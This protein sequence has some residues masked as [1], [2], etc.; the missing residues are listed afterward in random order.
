MKKRK[1]L[2]ALLASAIALVPAFSGCSLV[3]SN[4][5]ADMQQVIATVNISEVDGLSTADQNLVDTY[6]DA[7]GTTS[8][9]KRELIAYYLNVGYSYVETYGYE[10][11]F[12]MLVDGLAENAVLTQY[13]TMY[14]LDN[15]ASE[16]P[17]ALSEYNAK[18]TQVGKLEYLLGGENSDDVKIAKY[19]LYSSLN[20][21]IDSYEQIIL[22]EEHNHNTSSDTRTTP[23]NVNTEVEDYYPADENGNLNYNVYTG[24][25][26]YQIADSGA[27]VDDKLEDSTK[28]TR[29]RA[30]INFMS[31]VIDSNL[32]DPKKEDLRDV[33]KISYIQ[34][35]YVSQLENRVIEKYY[36][37]YEESRE[38]WL[39]ENNY[40]YLQEAYDDLLDYQ[41]ENNAT[42][43][44]IS[45]AIDN[46][47][48][49][50]F[51]LYSP[52]T[53]GEGIYGLVYNILLPFSAAQSARLT[54][55][56]TTYADPDGGYKPAYYTARNDLLKSIYTTDQRAAWFNGETEYAFDA[57]EAGITDF[58]G[59]DAGRGWLFFEDNLTKNDRYEKLDKYDGRYSYNGYVYE[60]DDDFT[61]VPARLT[62]DDMLD[63]FVNYVNYVLGDSG[64]TCSP[65]TK[66]DNYYKTYKS[67]STF[68]KNVEDKEID[69]SNFLY[70]SGK[71]NFTDNSAE[72]YREN[73]FVKES[74]QYK[75]L[76]AVN[77]LQYAYTTDTGVLSNYLG[78]SV[79]LGETTGYIKEFE[80]AAH[81]AIKGGAGSFNVCAGDYGWHI[82]YVTYTFGN[83]V[84][85]SSTGGNE[86]TPDWTKIE[87]EGTFE[88]LFYE[89]VK[90]NGISGISSSRRSQIITQF[91]A[92]SVTKY[93][94]RYQDLLDLGN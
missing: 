18:T 89:Q 62:I 91:K 88:N 32:V 4:S 38:E 90:S 6:K 94:S 30:Y 68:Y 7:V 73:L 8:I 61:L 35:E 24:Y 81:E 80:Y 47:S 34:N 54:E 36:D 58:Y 57:S 11:V 23:D 41:T 42:A 28:V 66:T 83:N 76:S 45:S 86:F 93:Q 43:S 59:K 75:A 12:N 9:L 27:Y 51:V 14:L 56:Q 15:L 64:A 1:I 17:N 87:E 19:K 33:L 50:S 79:S 21:A 39:T 84:N 22:D 67:D 13:A 92:K 48:D 72:Y 53:E 31:R 46:M 85:D 74:Q 5:A 2:C 16:N 82:L 69:Y 60:N 77:E 63:E 70:A 3:S 25:K 40:K 78:Y 65:A 29:I 26:G 37:L 49:S 10:Y 44:G 52:D 20:S 71:V 55:Y